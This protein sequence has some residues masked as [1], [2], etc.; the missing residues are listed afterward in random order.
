MPKYQRPH[1]PDFNKLVQTVSAV[2]TEVTS[3]AL[4][5]FATQERDAFVRRIEQQDFHSFDAAPLSPR[6]AAWKAKQGLD[7]RIMIANGWYKSQMQVFKR[8]NSKLSTTFHVGFNKRTLARDEDGKRV[9]FP[10]WKVA[11]VHEHGSVK[12]KIPARPHWRPHLKTM[13]MHAA[14]VRTGIRRAIIKRLRKAMPG[15]N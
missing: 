9:P 12:M 10:L 6:Y 11:R 4:Q 7:P 14:P 13:T 5:S 3:N 8:K 2:A 1:I 15:M